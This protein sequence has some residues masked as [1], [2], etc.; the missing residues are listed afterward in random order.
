[1]TSCYWYG[2]DSGWDS[3]W[4]YSNYILL[5]DILCRALHHSYPGAPLKF[6]FNSAFAKIDSAV[7]TGSQ[8]V[9]MMYIRSGSLTLKI[10]LHAILIYASVWWFVFS[11]VHCSSCHSVISSLLV[12]SSLGIFFIHSWHWVFPLTVIWCRMHDGTMDGLNMVT[13]PREGNYIY[14][15]V[16]PS[17]QKVFYG[18][19]N[20]LQITVKKE[21][22]I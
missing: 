14:I 17:I 12:T 2:F 1:M 9:Q 3:S 19:R 15:L 21:R 16:S 22:Y 6:E 7:T 13:N 4:I 5:S 8:L 10:R 20:Y 18:R 11:R